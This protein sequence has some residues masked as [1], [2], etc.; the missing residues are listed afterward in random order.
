MNI[1]KKASYAL[2]AFLSVSIFYV[3]PY[4][5]GINRYSVLV[6]VPL[7]ISLLGISCDKLFMKENELPKG[8]IMLLSICATI[9]TA[10]YLFAQ[11][12]YTFDRW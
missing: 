2:L 4:S 9:V 5:S 1:I 11:P 6:L 12:T 10:I 7:A 3:I 8:A